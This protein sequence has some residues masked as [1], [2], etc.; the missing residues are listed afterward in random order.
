M[1]EPTRRINQLRLE[2][3]NG[4][5]KCCGRMECNQQRASAKVPILLLRKALVTKL[6]LEDIYRRNLHCGIQSTVGIFRQ[7]Y[8]RPSVGQEKSAASGKCVAC[9]R[10]IR[11]PF[12]LPK[13]PPIPREITAQAKPLGI[14]DLTTLRLCS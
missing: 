5:V 3:D 7:H 1:E 10:L 6:I 11:A 12:Q 2:V 4:T 9:R 13:M 14:V 8:L